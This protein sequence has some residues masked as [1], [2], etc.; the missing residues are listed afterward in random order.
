MLTSAV[1]AAPPIELLRHVPLFGDLHRSDLEQ[2]AEAFEE[3]TFEAGATLAEQGHAGAT[4]FV[5][6]R[7]RLSVRI[8]GAQVRTLSPGDAFGEVGLVDESHLR[9]ATVVADTDVAAYA[10][11]RWEFEAVLDQHPIVARRL[12][13]RLAKLIRETA[14]QSRQAE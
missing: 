5:V 12:I 10:L 7:G 11:S 4:L 13:A 1:M 2:L 6:A 3:R 14:P 9:S 8:N